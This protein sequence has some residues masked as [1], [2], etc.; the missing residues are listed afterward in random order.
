MI[1]Y[2][3]NNMVVIMNEKVMSD[4]VWFI[5]CVRVCMKFIKSDLYV[6]KVWMIIVRFLFLNN[7]LI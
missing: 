7:F 6:V 2:W 1:F 3:E 5:F 4:E